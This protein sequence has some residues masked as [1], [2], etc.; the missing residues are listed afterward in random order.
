MKKILGIIGLVWL[1]SIGSIGSAWAVPANPRPF[2]YEQPNGDTL[3]IR[4][5]GDEHFHYVTTVDG[6]LVTKNAKGYYVYAKWQ[7]V[8][9]DDERARYRV[10]GTWRKARNADKRSRWE[11]RWVEKHASQGGPKRD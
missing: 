2:G 8:K 3:M 9:S 11:K 5:V 7:T 4:L 6:I 1:V 10:K